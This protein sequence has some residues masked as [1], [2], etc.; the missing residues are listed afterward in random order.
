M[1]SVYLFFFVDFRCDLIKLVDVVVFVVE[2]I[3]KSLFEEIFVVRLNEEIVVEPLVDEIVDTVVGPDI[4]TF[5][6]FFPS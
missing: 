2:F 5:N 4:T 6:E 3:A 1:T